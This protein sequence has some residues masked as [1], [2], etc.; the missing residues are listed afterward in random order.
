MNV[1]HLVGLELT[2]ETEHMADIAALSHGDTRRGDRSGAGCAGIVAVGTARGKIQA[3]NSGGTKGS[4]SGPSGDTRPGCGA[5]E[6]VLHGEA[7]S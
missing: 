6:E 4:A 1:D 5:C 7:D 3:Q 2:S